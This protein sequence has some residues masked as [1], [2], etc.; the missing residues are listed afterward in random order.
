[1]T[2]SPSSELDTSK[3]LPQR[4]FHLMEKKENR[5]LANLT[6]IDICSL[7]YWELSSL[8]NTD[9]SWQSCPELATVSSLYFD[10]SLWGYL[11]LGTWYLQTHLTFL[12]DCRPQCP[13]MYGMRAAAV[14]SASAST[15]VLGLAI[16]KAMLLWLEPGFCIPSCSFDWLLLRLSCCCSAAYSKVLNLSF[17]LALFC[18]QCS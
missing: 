3:D 9:S 4:G 12:L 15:L 8:T 16:T 1:M 13:D 14:C 11:T 10:K 2:I 6:I 7:C 5:T 18:S 17:T